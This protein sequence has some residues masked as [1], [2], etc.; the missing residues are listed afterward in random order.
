MA[1]MNQGD[2]TTG[3][4]PATRWIWGA[5]ALLFALTL[6]GA[7]AAHLAAQVEPHDPGTL[8][9]HAVHEAVRFEGRLDRGAVHV[10]SDGEIHL[11]LVATGAEPTERMLVRRPTDVVVVLDRS[12]SMEGEPLANA[13]AA[14]RELV[15]QLG[16]DDR[17]ALVTYANDAA[18]AIP[19][20]RAAGEARSSW[21]SR[22]GA[23]VAGGGT[24]MSA[25]LDRAHDLV[26]A[27]RSAGRMARIVLLSD[28][29]ANQGDATPEG[30]TRRSGR[31]TAGEY[32]L[33]TVGVGE[34]F[35][36]R[37]MS[38][39]ADAG[40]G[41]F[42]YVPNVE[43]LAGIFA[44]EFES[45]R[46]TL[47]TA[48]EIRIDTP[49]G[50]QVVDAAGYPIERHADHATLRPGP[51]FAGQQRSFWV[52]LRVPAAEAGTIA[53]GDV[54]LGYTPAAGGPR[55]A[56]RLPTLPAIAAVVDE[57][58]FVA[59]LDKDAVAAHHAEDVVNRIRQSV[60]E[61]VARGAYAEAQQRLDDVDYSE[62]RALGYEPEATESF[63]DVLEIKKEVD[64]AAAAPAMEQGKV[65]SRLG[66]SLYESGT[67]GRRQGAKR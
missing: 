23:V 39:L 26:V 25:G 51:L 54:E 40:S 22:L 45:A 3:T 9:R 56:L 21:M 38:R 32:V 60:S 19:L 14:I 59:S 1:T 30:L 48:L 33:S 35:D 34:G 41:N 61:L 67:D 17:F 47:A 15:G 6:G 37:L 53:L 16:H 7:H 5:V 46:Q 57:T 24:N 63:A 29:H 43:V 2:P 49:R 66:K 4:G 12:G 11:E 8:T 50:V 62:L 18:L 44:D 58:R 28:G 36:E 13:L 42:Y 27:S 64:A 20:A 65:R 52:T 55:R 10:G 31:A